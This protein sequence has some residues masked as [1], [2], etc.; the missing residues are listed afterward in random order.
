MAVTNLV[1]T[2]ESPSRWSSGS[3]QRPAPSRTTA[4]RA[5]SPHVDRLDIQIV[6]GEAVPEHPGLVDLIDQVGV[7]TGLIEEPA[8]GRAGIALRG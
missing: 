1:A 3:I 4:G 7:D 8:Y 6:V 2:V 5:L